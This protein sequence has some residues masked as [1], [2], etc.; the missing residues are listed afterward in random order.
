MVAGLRVSIVGVILLLSALNSA[1]A[2]QF[3][4]RR[5]APDLIVAVKARDLETVRAMLT[6]QVDVNAPQPDG[7]TA[8]HWAVHWGELEIAELLMRAGASVNVVNDHDVTPVMVACGNGNGALVE[9]LLKAGAGSN[10]TLPTG[11]TALMVCARAGSLE[12]VTALLASGADPNASEPRRGQT[13]LMWAVSRGHA[14][15]AKALIEN[16]ADIHARSHGGFTPVLFAARVGDVESARVLLSA[17]ID[18]NEGGASDGMIPLSMAAAS[19][20]EAV[21]IFLVENGAD[22]NAFDGGAAPLHY[23]VM[24]GISYLHFRSSMP[25]LVKTLL[26]HGADPDVQ[27]VE[28]RVDGFRANLRGATPLVIA[29]TSADIDTIRILLDAGA[30]PQLPTRSRVTPLMAAAGM[31]RREAFPEGKEDDALAALE[32]MVAL[33]GD[34]TAVDVDGRTA[35]HM[36][37]HLAADGV[38]R[39]L[40]DHGAHVDARDKYQQTPLSAAMGI[41]LPW[42][43]K[44]EELGE[45]GFVKTSTARLLIELGAAPVDAP[46]YFTPV[47]SDSDVSR[48]NPNQASIPGLNPEK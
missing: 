11:R 17:G 35:L 38:V 8:L 7:A 28:S 36:A 37:T 33:G 10:T 5:D 13:A 27:L 47:D 25:E 2:A 44:N 31:L 23:A 1:G 20:H 3:E 9:M 4:R 40:G 14:D 21:S 12:G 42:V 22:P 6:R 19:G 43:P 34:V 48:F 24:E 39:F 26:A 41:R 16:G 18:V 30:D 46:G 29:A 45:E 15:V 32:L